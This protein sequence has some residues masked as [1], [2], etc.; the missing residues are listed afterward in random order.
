MR[1]SWI[2]RLRPRPTFQRLLVLLLLA[3]IVTAVGL[4]TW[5]NVRGSRAA[6][7]QQLE[8]LLD[9]V[10]LQIVDHC[11]AYLAKP[12]IINRI[13]VESV[14]SGTLD[15]TDREQL[16]SQFLNLGRSFD[17]VGTIGFA[18]PSGGYVALNYAERYMV[19]SDS[20]APGTFVRYRIDSDGVR[21]EPLAQ[22]DGYD[23]RNRPWFA[24]AERHQLPT[25]SEI[26]PSVARPGLDATA[27]QPVYDAADRLLGVFMSEVELSQLNDFL[28]GLQISESGEAFIVDNLGRSIA[29]SSHADVSA[30]P[31][32][33]E[34]RPLSPE[35][36]RPLARAAAAYLRQSVPGSGGELDTESAGIDDRFMVRVANLSLPPLDW[37][38]AVVI[39]RSDFLHRI[40]ASL[41][42]TLYLSLAILG[43]AA[44]VGTIVGRQISRPLEDLAQSAQAVASGDLKPRVDVA[45]NDEI[46]TLA[47]AFNR[48]AEQLEHTF[49]DLSKRHAELVE[50]KERLRSLT[51]EV[52]L[53]E[54]RERRR[55]ASD[56][57]DT[58]VQTLGLVR[59]RLG[60]LRQTLAGSQ[61]GPLTDEITKLVEEAIEQAR[62][63]LY[64]LAPPAL[65]EIG[66]PE[67]LAWLGDQLEKRFPIRFTLYPVGDFSHLGDDVKTLLFQACR[68]L[69]HNVVKHASASTITITLR[70]EID[71]V[72]SVVEDDGQGFDIDML[73]SRPMDIGGY[74][75][76]SIRE[77]FETLGGHMDISSSP[78][79]GTRVTL[80]VPVSP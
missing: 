67:G 69:S 60:K 42:E 26:T 8:Q 73:R 10:S 15:T 34:L 47:A 23:A 17:G 9:R 78:D 65:Y 11:E 50:H 63:L 35:S 66:L 20:P 29:S 74:G 77:R 41:R 3:Q 36:G 59:I 1:R 53:A 79:Q 18:D 39:P 43:F 58:T 25:W 19:L 55:I 61:L 49:E 31:G 48:M 70:A 16:I 80:F 38:V 44:I 76:F 13:N 62:A 51:S 33:R 40:D 57:H 54:G 12:R 30:A 7:D 75:I 14:R 4:V 22:I 24:S 45:R 68:E 6:I 72:T 32:R 5:V 52:F 64:E 71:G 56:V 2:R 21:L 28:R 27:A 37:R 46:G